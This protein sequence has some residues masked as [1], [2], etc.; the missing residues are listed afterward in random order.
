MINRK[1]SEYWFYIDSF[2]HISVKSRDVLYYNIY[3]GKIVE[4]PAETNGDVVLKLTRRLLSPKNL[5]VIRLTSRDL[6]IPEVSN[7]IRIIRQHFMGDLMNVDFSDTKPF[8][9]APN[10]PKVHFDVKKVMEDPDQSPG[11][12]MMAHVFEITLYLNDFCPQRCVECK[13]FYKQGIWCRKG[14]PRSGN[15]EGNHLD[16]SHLRNFFHD[17][18]GCNLNKINITGGNVLLYPY[19]DELYHL[20]ESVEFKVQFFIHYLN[21]DG[22]LEPLK[23]MK[24]NG[25]KI[26]LLANFPLGIDRFKKAAELLSVYGLNV[27]PVFFVQNDEEYSVLEELLSGFPMESPVFLPYYNKNNLDFFKE[28]FF[29][30]R[31]DIEAR[32]P[33]QRVIHGNSK[34]NMDNFGK[35]TIFP[36]G[37]VHANV[38][39][40]ALGTLG[41]DSIYDIVYR[42]LTKGRSW[43]RLRKNVMPCRSCN[44]ELLCPSLSNYNRVIGRNDLCTIR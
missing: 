16:I 12:I 8:Q 38:M 31:E 37:K 14:A 43:F 35:I 44:F 2:V 42:E 19:M 3:S 29:I 25:Y 39:D 40:P 10:R 20:L 36:N 41:K 7:F 4:F 33:E 6:D 1:D 32:K 22:N 34:I 15:A 30:S 9:P 23:Q 13:G 21:I 18:E 27:Q 24:K 26:R 11:K 5:R 17:I 28:N